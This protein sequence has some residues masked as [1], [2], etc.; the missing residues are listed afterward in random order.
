MAAPSMMCVVKRG[1]SPRA[2]GVA[3]ETI[4]FFSRFCT[5]GQGRSVYVSLCRRD[6]GRGPRG[7]DFEPPL[8]T[9]VRRCCGLLFFFLLSFFLSLW[10]RSH[11]VPS[12]LPSGG[13]RRSRQSTCR[14]RRTTHPTMRGPTGRALPQKRLTTAS[15][16]RTL[17]RTRWCQLRELVE[18]LGGPLGDN[19][20]ASPVGEFCSWLPPLPAS[21]LDKTPLRPTLLNTPPAAAMPAQQL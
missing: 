4:A 3:H 5:A 19:C 18:P 17:N 1:K 12:L 9:T 16:T 2:S 8:W 6:R 20:C 10:Q 14:C 11:G 13:P 7:P 21:S 15:Q